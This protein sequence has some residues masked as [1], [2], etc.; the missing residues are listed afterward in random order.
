[1]TVLS[2]AVVCRRRYLGSNQI[3]TIANGVFTGLTALLELYD[4]G[5]LVLFYLC[6]GCLVLAWM[7]GP[8]PPELVCGLLSFIM[9][10][11]PHFAI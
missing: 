2:H 4:A 8:V 11:A 1:V 3:S 7:R 5:L 9:A 10:C 6:C